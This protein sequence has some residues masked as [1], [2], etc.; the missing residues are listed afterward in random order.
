MTPSG[1]TTTSTISIPE[2]HVRLVLLNDADLSFYL[3]IPLTVIPSLCLDSVK[4]LLFL[5]WCIL[6]V[7][8]ILSL[9]PDGE[10]L[11]PDYDIED[12]EIYYYVL[13]EGIFFS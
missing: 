1:S 5:G 3:E 7:E 12:R 11:D 13:D 6:G 2:G 8:G 10:K 4:Y 9:D